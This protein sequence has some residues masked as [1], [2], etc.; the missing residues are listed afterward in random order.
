ME[1]AEESGTGK[2]LLAVGIV[3]AIGVVGLFLMFM[4]TGLTAQAVRP[5]ISDVTL[6]GCN[7]GEVLLSPNGVEALKQAGREKYGPDFSPY[8]AASIY[9]NQVGYC[10]NA[11][12]VRSL[13][14]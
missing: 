12:V 4:D 10:A 6:I 14:G 11:E 2:H 5:G 1:Q 3:A 13:L 7:R 8:D 9:Y